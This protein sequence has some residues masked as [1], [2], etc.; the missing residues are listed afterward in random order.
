[1]DERAVAAALARLVGP[2]GSPVVTADWAQ[3][4]RTF[5]LPSDVAD[6]RLDICWDMNPGDRA[7]ID[8]VTLHCDTCR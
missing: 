1:M 6:G 2:D 8:D 7:W 3:V 4:S 5:T